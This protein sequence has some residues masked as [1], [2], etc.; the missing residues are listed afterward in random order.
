MSGVTECAWDGKY[1]VTSSSSLWA[2]LDKVTWHRIYFLCL[3]NAKGTFI[4]CWFEKDLWFRVGVVSL[5]YWKDSTNSNVNPPLW[6]KQKFGNNQWTKS[7]GDVRDSKMMNPILTVSW[8]IVGRIVACKARTNCSNLP[9]SPPSGQS[10]K[11]YNILV[12]EEN[13]CDFLLSRSCT[14]C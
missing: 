1:K 8:L 13:K 7:Y 5:C 12:C 4:P 10:F 9:L 2:H 6:L 11:L 3:Q 14:H